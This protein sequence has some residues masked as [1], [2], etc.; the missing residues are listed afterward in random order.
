M[1][2]GVGGLKNQETLNPSGKNVSAEFLEKKKTA[3]FYLLLSAVRKIQC[4]F[5]RKG[6]R[7]QLSILKK[8]QLHLS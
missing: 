4:S 2:L 6:M 8:V 5:S 1:D 7:P 3:L